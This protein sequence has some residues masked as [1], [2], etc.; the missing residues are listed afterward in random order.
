[1]YIYISVISV[2]VGFTVCFYRVRL[3]ESRVISYGMFPRGLA[4][5]VASQ[6]RG[7]TIFM[8]SEL[9]SAVLKS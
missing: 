9:V 6:V 5:V 1:M 7:V 2:Y 8:V 4:T 3:A